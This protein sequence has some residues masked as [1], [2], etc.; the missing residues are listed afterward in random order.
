M[1]F[2]CVLSLEVRQIRHLD[3]LEMGALSIVVK[4]SRNAIDSLLLLFGLF[5]LFCLFPARFLIS[6]IYGL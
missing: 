2:F 1:A 5:S 6:D 3:C 4:E